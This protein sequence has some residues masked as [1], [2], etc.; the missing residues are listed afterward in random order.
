MSKKNREEK[1]K[2]L[3]KEFEYVRIDDIKKNPVIFFE[4]HSVD[5]CIKAY[6]ILKPKVI[7]IDFIPIDFLKDPLFANL[8]SI[9]VSAD[10]STDITHLHSLKN[11]KNLWFN[12]NLEPIGQL[13]FSQFPKLETLRYHWL[14]GS[15]NISKLTSLKSIYISGFPDL[16]LKLFKNMELLKSME[17]YHSKI[18]SL[19]GI[20]NLSNLEELKITIS[21]KIKTLKRLAQM[22]T[23]S[24]KTL[25]ISSDHEIK[26]LEDISNLNTL[27]SLKLDFIETLDVSHLEK[28]TKLKELAIKSIKKVV[29][30][31]SLSQLTKLRSLDF[32]SIGFIKSLNFLSDLPNL[33]K[34]NL[35]PS[36]ANVK[37]GYLPLIQKYRSLNKLESLFN[38][39]GIFDLLDEEGKNQYKA[40][41][42]DS[43]LDFIKKQF[44]FHCYE[45]FSEPYT[46]ENCNRIDVEIRRLIDLLIENADKSTEEK[47]TYFEETANKLDKIDE[48]L[49]FFATGEREYLWDT[50]D[51]IAETSGID[52]DSLEES[53]SNNKYFKWPVF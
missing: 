13:D 6:E 24:L 10:A 4:E 22:S 18:E 42:G 35:P 49:D 28:N 52:V 40:H 3:G 38:W 14:E 23:K 9:N 8:E 46:E 15:K 7:Y 44:K 25:E 36:T 47:L 51:E 11:L 53:D 20:E 19:E 16:D 32:L 12:F 1:I 33:K 48:E 27:Q 41:F 17:I 45:D 31:E 34:L 30:E 37:D 29:N 5:L 50:L 43:P 26:G 39:D 2:V 21:S